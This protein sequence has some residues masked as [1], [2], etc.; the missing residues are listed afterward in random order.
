MLPAAALFDN[1]G[2]TLDTE[3][4]WTRAEVA[5]FARHGQTWTMDH[6]REL[7]GTSPA[8]AAV[9]LERMLGRPG[10]Q[11]SA[12]LYDLVVD[13][14]AEGIEPMPGAVALLAALRAAGVP[15]GL[16]SNSRRRFV[17]LGLATAGLADA[18]DAIVTAE[19]VARPKP[20]PDAYVAAAR[21]LGAAPASCVVLEDSPPGLAAGLAAGARTIGV[22]SLEGVT[23]EADV[24]AA[25]LEDRAV[26]QALGLQAAAA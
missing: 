11:L 15:L 13:E 25:S 20:A 24:V 14:V 5:L 9:K 8:T 19:D 16:V 18:F 17:E 2:L 26:W 22:P 6:K 10:A 4:A 23:L 21:A 12:E 1:D 3:P 7:L